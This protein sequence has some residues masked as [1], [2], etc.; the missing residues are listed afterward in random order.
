MTDCHAAT[1]LKECIYLTLLFCH[2]QLYQTGDENHCVGMRL[3][4][5]LLSFSEDFWV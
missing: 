5:V 1:D 4:E 3:G 2:C